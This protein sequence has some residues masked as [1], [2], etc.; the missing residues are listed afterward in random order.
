MK[1]W[2]SVRIEKGRVKARIEEKKRITSTKIK[3]ED[4]ASWRH[5]SLSTN[6]LSCVRNELFHFRV[7]DDYYHWL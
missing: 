1:L 3:K 6:N 7:L 4:L 5:K 2:P